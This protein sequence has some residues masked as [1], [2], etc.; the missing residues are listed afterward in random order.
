METGSV[1]IERLRHAFAVIQRTCLMHTMVCTACNVPWF[2]CQLF[3]AVVAQH[4]QQDGMFQA[5]YAKQWA[6]CRQTMLMQSTMRQT[7]AGGT[8]E[9]HMLPP[10]G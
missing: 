5:S 10:R 7:A 9:P 4:G 1:K 2:R 6:L 3:C 8:G